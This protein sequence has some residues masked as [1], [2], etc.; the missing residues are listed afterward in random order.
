MALERAFDL[1]DFGPKRFWPFRLKSRSSP[2][3]LLTSLAKGADTIAAEAALAREA[4]H[5]VVPLPL[6]LDLYK[7]DFDTEGAA[8]LDR[9]LAHPRTRSFVLPSLLDKE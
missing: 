2:R 9:L 5:V 7:Q 4:W 1:I 6:P 8:R 3:I